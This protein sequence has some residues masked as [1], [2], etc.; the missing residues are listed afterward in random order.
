MTRRSIWHHGYRS[1]FCRIS[2]AGSGQLRRGAAV[3]AVAGAVARHR[4]RA[5]R[6]HH[7]RRPGA[8]L[9][10]DA[11]NRSAMTTPSTSTGGA[12]RG[13]AW[14]RPRG[15]PE[16]VPPSA[17]HGAHHQLR[18]SFVFLLCFFF[19]VFVGFFG[20]MSTRRDGLARNLPVVLSVPN[21]TEFPSWVTSSTSCIANIAVTNASLLLLLLLF[22][23]YY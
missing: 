9:L 18:G 22:L 13:D 20:T 23:L 15:L 5:A 2:G 1:I 3:A 14:N 16:P 17:R 11:L 6:L 12:G 4:R 21:F 10:V 7:P 19:H 8:C